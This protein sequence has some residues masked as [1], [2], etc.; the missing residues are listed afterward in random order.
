MRLL[1]LFSGTGSIGRAFDE[2]GWEVTS[3]DMDPESGADIIA[4]LMDWDYHMYPPGYFDGIW[5]SPPCTHY[6]RARTR[7]KT[8]R[9]LEG[10]DAL[11]QR[12]KDVIEYFQ[13]TVWAF[14]NPA[15]G[16]L[17]GRAVVQSIPFKDISYCMY[18][19]P[20]QKHT[21]IWTNSTVWRPKPRCYKSVTPC[22][23]MVDGRHPMSAQRAPAK[24]DGVRVAGDKCS[25]RQLYSM[26]R[27]LCDELAK[28]F[29]LEVS[30]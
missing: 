21:R 14:E 18:G 4:N 20:Y 8:P 17:P 1:E 13:P 2:I 5:G 22:E 19:F 15:T 11:V 23:M 7:A 9:D 6:S 3:L 16:L 24:R 28:A 26:P 12:L 25:L 10:S 29:D 30:A 27:E